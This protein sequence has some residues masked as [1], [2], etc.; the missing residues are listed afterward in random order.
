MRRLIRSIALIGSLLA[1]APA[2]AQQSEQPAEP[3]IV[4]EGMR[5][6]ERER[7]IER[8][9]D[10]LTPAPHGGQIGRFEWKICP[11]AVGLSAPQNAAIVKRMR[12]VAGA[13]GVP[14]GAADCS[15]NA[16]VIVTRDK[17][18]LI[19]R[20]QKTYPAYFSDMW[21]AQVRRIRDTP[22]PVAAWHVEALLD[23]DGNPVPR[24]VSTGVYTAESTGAASRLT[25]VTKPHFAAAVVVVEVEALAGLT[26][27]QL[28]DYAAMRTF[29]KTD[30]VRL[31]SSAAPTILSVIDAPMGSE[32]PITLTLWDL[33]FLRALYGAAENHYAT[34]QRSQMRGLVQEELERAAPG[35]E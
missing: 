31:A 13:A 3:D 6:P 28:A 15:P 30:P 18:D 10:A 8:F 32:V 4:V 27:T 19:D 1:A 20:L 9:V 33:S 25:P 7:E 22:G 16:I 17:G 14:L 35:K 29:A 21:D 24:D 5:G 2:A 11:G 23:R 12:Q 26:T 34:Q